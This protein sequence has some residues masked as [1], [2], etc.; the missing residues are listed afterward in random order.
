MGRSIKYIT[1]SGNGDVAYNK[2]EWRSASLRNEDPRK[3][4]RS[5]IASVPSMKS[6]MSGSRSNAG[7]R[8]SISLTLLIPTDITS[9]VHR[10]AC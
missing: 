7:T 6:P 9:F 4:G 1:H 5:T 3:V 2:R 10:S 8:T